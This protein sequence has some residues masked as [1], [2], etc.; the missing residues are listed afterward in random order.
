MDCSIREGRAVVKSGSGETFVITPL[1]GGEATA[2]DEG[3]GRRWLEE[4]HSWRSAHPRK[5]APG[6][7]VANVD[8][9]LPGECG[10][11]QGL[12]D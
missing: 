8:R 4:H 6:L 2:L 9:L 3:T 7:Q 1:I 12:K 10:C 11:R 5:C